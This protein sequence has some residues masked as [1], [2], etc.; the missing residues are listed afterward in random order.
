[1]SGHQN[2]FELHIEP[3]ISPL[4]PQKSQINPKIKPKSNVRIE[5]NKKKMKVVQLH[6]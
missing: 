5:K 3:K 4:G 2:S 6:E 1:M